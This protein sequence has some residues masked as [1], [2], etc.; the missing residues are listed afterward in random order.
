[1]EKP[2]DKTPEIPLNI[3]LHTF[4]VISILQHSSPCSFPAVTDI[5]IT[6]SLVSHALPPEAEN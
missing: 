6:N 3:F 2:N 5:P 4:F 1:M